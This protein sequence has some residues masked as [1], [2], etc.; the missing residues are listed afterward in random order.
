MAKSSDLGSEFLDAICAETASVLRD[1]LADVPQETAHMVGEEVAVRMSEKMGG[2]PIYIAKGRVFQARRSD[3]LI[4][5][6][7]NGQNH[8]EV[9]RKH[10]VSLTHVYRVVQRHTARERA[11]RQSTL[12]L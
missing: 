10:K 4:A 6:E 8:A 2:V 1:V 9:A 5:N 12:E 7:C 3:E 11:E